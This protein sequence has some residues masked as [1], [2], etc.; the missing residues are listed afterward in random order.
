MGKT[1]SR[2]TCPVC[3][4]EVNARGLKG[5]LRLAHG[6]MR[7]QESSESTRN[8]EVGNMAEK[9]YCPECQRKDLEREVANLKHE[10]ELKEAATEA[11]RVRAELAEARKSADELRVAGEQKLA[12][13]LE[14]ANEQRDFDLPSFEAIIQHCES[15]ECHGDH[16]AE[17]LAVKEKVGQEAIDNIGPEQVQELMKKLNIAG[18]ASQRI[19][20]TG[21][22]KQRART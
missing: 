2:A 1:E 20:I 21:L 11:E 4:K 16:A 8:K 18:G 5:H 10:N 13:A 6:V 14:A 9:E 7:S 19:V 17:W 12:E 15:G 3:D 22:D